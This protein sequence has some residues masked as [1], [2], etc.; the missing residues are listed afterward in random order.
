[1]PQRATSIRRG[2]GTIAGC[3][4]RG[5]CIAI[6]WIKKV[7]VLLAGYVDRG[8]AALDEMAPSP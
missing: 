4:E 3:I 2:C 5:N 6:G 8:E 7:A 1:M